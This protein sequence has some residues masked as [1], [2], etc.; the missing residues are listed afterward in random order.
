M[1]IA[2]WNING[3]KA[4]LVN[5]IAWLE[6]AEPH[7]ACLQEIKSIDENFPA[8]PLEDLGY[9]VATHGQKSFNGVALLSKIPF[10]EVT[11][12]LPGDDDDPQARY[13]EA[14]FS[15][16]QGVL[17]VC[18]LY[19][20]NGNPVTSDKYPYKL[21]WMKRLYAH[22]RELLRLE[23]PLVLAGDFNIIPHPRDVHDPEAWAEDALFRIES[24]HAFRRV[25]NLG[26]Y[27]AFSLADGRGH[28]YTFWDFQRGAWAKDFGLRIDHLLLSAQAADRLRSCTID[29]HTR[30]WERPSDHVPVSI[31][32][33]L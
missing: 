13:I 8:S 33:N 2:T 19:L 27:D 22:A 26:L 6:E 12:G 31:R 5:V 20:P 23:E 10:D 15:R 7:I 11:R 24:R 16:P 4:R 25:L 30:G 3:I 29:R 14:V 17:R 9:Q 32:L 21:A 18:C 1:K 28:Q